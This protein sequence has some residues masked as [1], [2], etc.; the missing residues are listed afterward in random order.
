MKDLKTAILIFAH[1]AEYEAKVKPFQYS[2]EV[3]ESLNQRTLELVK[4]TNLPYFVV[5]EKEQI[6]STFG[7]RFTHAIE[8]VYDLNY[9]SV[10]VIGNDTP[11]LTANQ[12]TSANRKLSTSD[13]IFGSSID[14]GFYLLG[15]KRE[16]FDA[17]L[18]LKL[19]WQSQILNAALTK[20]FKVNAIKVAYLEKLRDIDSLHDIKKLFNSFKT[21]YGNLFQL[22]LIIFSKIKKTIYE[23][24]VSPVFLFQSNF[25]NKGSPYLF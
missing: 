14:G 2:K 21:V 15:I 1:T 7:E 5:T 12:L 3:F 23:I 11:H 18:F 17:N 10:I 8:S 4:K 25:G 24:E 20:Y 22:F 19:P 6:G 13:I 9:D 16:H